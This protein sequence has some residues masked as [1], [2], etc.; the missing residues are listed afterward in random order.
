MGEKADNENLDGL[1]GMTDN[2][3]DMQ[4]LR[5]NDVTV[6]V[7]IHRD[8]KIWKSPLSLEVSQIGDKVS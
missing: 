4:K 3:V 7:G 1:A 2:I 5:S 8:L 6:P